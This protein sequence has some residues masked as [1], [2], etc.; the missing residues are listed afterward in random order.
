[1]CESECDTHGVSVCASVCLCVFMRGASGMKVNALTCALASVHDLDCWD[2]K[3]GA[4]SPRQ[5]KLW[6]MLV[7]ILT[8][9]D[10]QNHQDYCSPTACSSKADD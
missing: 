7:A 6:W 9:K 3:D 4:R 1:M 8:C 2:L 10:K 5:G